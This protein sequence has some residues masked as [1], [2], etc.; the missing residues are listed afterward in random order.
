MNHQQNDLTSVLHPPIELT[1]KR[2]LI[3]PIID[4]TLRLSKTAYA[5]K[6]ISNN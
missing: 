3:K 4:S 6:R 1:I 5:H 2:G